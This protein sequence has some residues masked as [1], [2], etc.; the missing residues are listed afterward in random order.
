MSN[1]EIAIKNLKNRMRYLLRKADNVDNY[2]D[3]AKYWNQA[4]EIQSV[5][6]H[7]EHK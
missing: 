5:L 7:I 2:F 3:Y 6:Y 4:G 1:K